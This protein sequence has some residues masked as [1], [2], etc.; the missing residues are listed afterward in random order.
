MYAPR[1]KHH[2]HRHKT[3]KPPETGNAP[4]GWGTGRGTPSGIVCRER[5]W[6]PGCVRRTSYEKECKTEQR[7]PIH[8]TFAPSIQQ[9]TNIKGYAESTP[10]QGSTETDLDLEALVEVDIVLPA[11][12]GLVGV[13][14]AGVKAHRLQIGLGL[15]LGHLGQKGLG[16]LVHLRAKS[17][18]E[19]KKKG[20]SPCKMTRTKNKAEKQIWPR[21]RCSQ[22]QQ[23]NHMQW[24]YELQKEKRNRRKK[25]KDPRVRKNR[26]LKHASGL[27][28]ANQDFPAPKQHRLLTV[29]DS[30]INEDQNYTA[31]MGGSRLP[32]TGRAKKRQTTAITSHAL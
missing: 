19:N 28:H 13:G 7:K 29:T 23:H 6:H 21:N 22:T 18:Q 9:A 20:P 4:T 2:R 12:A 11:S 31:K 3:P 25:N 32:N 15:Q 5:R 24:P 30:K 17:E 14:E 10:L 26:A 16:A 8:H 27:Q 1:P